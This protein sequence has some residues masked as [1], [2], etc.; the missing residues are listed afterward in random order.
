MRVVAGWGNIWFFS[1][2]VILKMEMEARG[3]LNAWAAEENRATMRTA[4]H[5]FVW[6][7]NRGRLK[8]FISNSMF[9]VIRAPQSFNT[10]FS[11]KTH[12]NWAVTS[13]HGYYIWLWVCLCLSVPTSGHYS[14]NVRAQ[15]FKMKLAE[16]QWRGEKNR[17]QKPSLSSVNRFSILHIELP[18]DG[19]H[20]P[21]CVCAV[22]PSIHFL[23]DTS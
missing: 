12:D 20:R 9:T 5:T 22:Q 14:V 6:V 2:G 17:S 16:I 19:P 7:Q 11:V 15:G 18:I 1:M 23:V 3:E 21:V 10:F 8:A 4:A 13:A